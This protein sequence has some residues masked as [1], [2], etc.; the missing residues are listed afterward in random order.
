MI[1]AAIVRRRRIG[2]QDGVS[3][4]DLLGL[5]ALVLLAV[6]SFLLALESA[7]DFSSDVALADELDA[8]LSVMYQPDPLK[9]IPTG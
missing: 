4:V 5:S 6:E 3:A 2:G 7:L 1:A 8:R 9:M